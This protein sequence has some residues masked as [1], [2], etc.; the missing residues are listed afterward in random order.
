MPKVRLINRSRR[1]RSIRRARKRAMPAGLKAYWAKKR[2]GNASRHSAGGGHMPRRKRR[3]HA[4]RHHRRRNRARMNRR[5]PTMLFGAP[6]RHRRHHRRHNRRM[7]RHHR[8]RHRNP[9]FAELTSGS[10]ISMVGGGAI[11]FFGARMIPQNLPML[12]SYNSGITGYLM[13][14]GSGL[15]ISWALGK[16]WNKQAGEG[17]LVGTAIAVIARFVTDQMGTATPSTTANTSAAV[18]GMGADLDM[19]LGYYIEQFPFPQG[20]S[21]GPYG[22]PIGTPY[23]SVPWA[24]TNAS[25]V[26]AGQSAAVAAL[27]AGQPVA[28][29]PAASTGHAD[30]WTN[31]W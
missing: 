7:N 9:S 20:A 23:T 6:K 5:N 21:A 11:G 10:M 2:A 8:R 29:G 27:P 15:A 22:F 16:F 1:R 31:G 4:R 19:D 24:N 3:T 30:R 26:R 13:N 12:S 18:S 25:A 14:A 28:A 17:A